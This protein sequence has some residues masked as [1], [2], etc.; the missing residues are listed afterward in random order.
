[1]PEN[2]VSGKIR[3]GTVVSVGDL[4]NILETI[5]RSNVRKATREFKG[6]FPVWSRGE[7]APS[8]ID[9]EK[10]LDAFS[11]GHYFPFDQQAT[12]SGEVPLIDCAGAAMVILAGGLIKTIGSDDFDKLF[13]SNTI[14]MTHAPGDADQ[15]DLGDWGYFKNAPGYRGTG[16]QGENVINVGYDKFFG[17]PG[18]TKPG[19]GGVKSAEQWCNTLIKAYNKEVHFWQKIKTLPEDCGWQPSV[20]KFI[21]V[22]AVALKLFKLRGGH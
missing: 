11:I 6:G 10:S 7:V 20:N 2:P 18:G 4:L 8:Y 19:L 9:G 1:M 3:A 13:T 16:F 5:I 22:P 15:A 17:F 12:L 14:P 21:D